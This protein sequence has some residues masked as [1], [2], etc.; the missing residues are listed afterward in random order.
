MKKALNKY[1]IKLLRENLNNVYLVKL[2]YF[3]GITAAGTNSRRS[4]YISNNGIEN[5]YSDEFIE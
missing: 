4:V 2:I 5:G 1:P 3:S